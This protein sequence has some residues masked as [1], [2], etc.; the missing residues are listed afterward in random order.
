MIDIRLCMESLVC[1]GMG[2]L[3]LS[4]NSGNND[5]PV[6]HLTSIIVDIEIMEVYVFLYLRCESSMELV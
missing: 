6:T 1:D 3:G 5:R 2:D 4:H